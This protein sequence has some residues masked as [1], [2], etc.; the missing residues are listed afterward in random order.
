MKIRLKIAKFNTREIQNLQVTKF[1]ARDIN[2]LVRYSSFLEQIRMAK[3][4]FEGGFFFFFV[5]VFWNGL[6]FIIS[7]NFDFGRILK[8]KR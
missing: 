4:M 2:Y 7:H 8:A 6:V 5:F 3:G 1:N